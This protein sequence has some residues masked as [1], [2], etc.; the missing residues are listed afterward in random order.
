MKKVNIRFEPDETLDGIEIIIRAV[1]RD[2][3]VSELIESF[4]Q[5][6]EF[7]I[8]ALD[9]NK[10]PSV[11]DEREV[12]FIAADGKD[13]RI[14]AVHGKYHARQ[15]LRSLEEKLSRAFLRVSRFEIINLKMVR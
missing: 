7:R 10:C 12:V 15:T 3:Q 1:G 6:E 5:R 11:I 13:V 4:S 9:Q 8:I 14:V 2:K